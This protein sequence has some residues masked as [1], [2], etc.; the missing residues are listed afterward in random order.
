M[1]FDKLQEGPIRVGCV[2]NWSETPM[3][4]H[5]DFRNSTK[6]HSDCRQKAENIIFY[7]S[8][9]IDPSASSNTSC[10]GPHTGQQYKQNT[11]TGLLQSNH[12]SLF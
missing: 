6:L 1:K 3:F 10:T 7:Q 11:F 4:G 2:L 8:S 12:R 9:N 5:F